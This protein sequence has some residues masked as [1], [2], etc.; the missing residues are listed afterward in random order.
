MCDT[1]SE[2]KLAL[3]DLGQD[4]DV[5]T[6]EPFNGIIAVIQPLV[7]EC[8]HPSTQLTTTRVARHQRDLVEKFDLKTEDFIGSV[9]RPSS[10]AGVPSDNAL[11]RFYGAD[12][13]PGKR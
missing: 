6:G 13:S 12:Q 5:S 2:L 1:G 8:C 4:S 9:T 11:Y 3:W 10:L 7:A